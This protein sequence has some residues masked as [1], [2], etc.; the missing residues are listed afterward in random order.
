MP[1][2]KLVNIAGLP[3]MS[4]PC[5]LSS[6]DKLPI[7]LQLI[8]NRFREEDIFKVAYVMEQSANFSTLKKEILMRQ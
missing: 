6:K 5:G 1:L 2:A 4:V 8:A 7:G 3:A